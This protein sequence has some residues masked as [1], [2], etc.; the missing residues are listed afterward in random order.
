MST[1][2][3]GLYHKASYSAMSTAP[4]A[5]KSS[6]IIEKKGRF[7]YEGTDYDIVIW[8]KSI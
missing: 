6:R 3:I 5:L 8:N 2:Q 1:S 4:F 7:Y